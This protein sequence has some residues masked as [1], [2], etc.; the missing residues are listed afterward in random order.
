MHYVKSTSLQT[1][2]N[3]SGVILRSH[4]EPGKPAAEV[5]HTFVQPSVLQLS[6]FHSWTTCDIDYF[7]RPVKVC[8]EKGVFLQH[9][10]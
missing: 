7:N 10:C 9:L 1:D 5:G 6:G 2:E 3:Y 4:K 8:D